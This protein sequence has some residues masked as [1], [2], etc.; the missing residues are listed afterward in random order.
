M[1]LWICL[2]YHMYLV[3][4]AVTCGQPSNIKVYSIANF[5]NCKFIVFHKF[6]TMQLE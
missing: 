3:T 6:C 2:M 1:L 4:Q 5:F